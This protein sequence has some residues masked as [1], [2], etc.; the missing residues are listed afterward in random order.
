MICFTYAISGILLAITG[1]LFVWGVFDAATQTAAWTVIFFFASAASSSAYLTVSEVFP[2]EMRGLA[3]AL[4]RLS[5]H[6]AR[7]ISELSLN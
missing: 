6:L 1:Q 5:A 2:L 3:I 7:I 4:F